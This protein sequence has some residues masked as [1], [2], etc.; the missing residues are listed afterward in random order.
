LSIYLKYW[1]KKM[2]RFQGKNSWVILTVT[3][4]GLITA[5][6]GPS[7]VSQCN[8]LIQV[9]NTAV[10]EVQAVTQGPEAS[11]NPEALVQIADT[12]DRAVDQ[13]QQVELQDEQLVEYQQSFIS[14]YQETSAA[15]RAIY[16]ASQNQNLEAAQTALGQLQAATAPEPVLVNNVNTYCGGETPAE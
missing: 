16:E 14:M 8:E 4:L 3:S 9:I 15:S 6:C 11:T 1:E 13:M 10:S 7:K 2:R 12:A 5:S